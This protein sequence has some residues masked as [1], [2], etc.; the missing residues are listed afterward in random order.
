M[1][2]AKVCSAEG[3]AGKAK[4][5]CHTL[6]TCPVTIRLTWDEYQR[7]SAAAKA[8]GVTMSQLIR[9][10]LFSVIVDGVQRSEHESK[11]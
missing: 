11:N 9:Q 2:K 5:A 7:L 8:A 10:D 3:R 4:K 1:E 6:R